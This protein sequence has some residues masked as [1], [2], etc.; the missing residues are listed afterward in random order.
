MSSGNTARRAIDPR[1]RG[2]NRDAQRRWRARQKACQ[3][4]YRCDADSLV[5]DMLKRRKY[6]EEHELE[7]EHEVGRAITLFLA[8]CEHDDPL[9]P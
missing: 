7:D 5:L 1:R 4:S 9:K 8:D 3:A 2:A 6:I